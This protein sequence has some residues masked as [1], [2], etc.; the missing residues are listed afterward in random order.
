MTSELGDFGFPNPKMSDLGKSD[1]LVRFV[2]V[3]PWQ[4]GKY[5]QK[6]QQ[7]E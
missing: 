4:K 2:G 5:Y 7:A 6:F 3:K 1:S